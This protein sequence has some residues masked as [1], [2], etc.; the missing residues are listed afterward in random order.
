[1][2]VRDTGPGIPEDQLTLV[3]RP[4]YRVDTAR[5]KADGTG[6]GMAIVQRIA[7]RYK[8]HASLHNVRPGPGLEITVSFPLAK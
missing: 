3:F 5:T 2:R 1:M 8:G 6:L 7:T 4:F